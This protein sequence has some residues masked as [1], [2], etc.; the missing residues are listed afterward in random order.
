[1][2]F[3]GKILKGATKSPKPVKSSMF[4]LGDIWPKSKPPKTKKG[5]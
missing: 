3:L 2:S 1:M 4:S 5:K